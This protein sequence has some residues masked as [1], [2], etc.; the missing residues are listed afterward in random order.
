MTRDCVV[1]MQED[2]LGPDTTRFLIFPATWSAQIAAPVC[3]ELDDRMHSWDCRS[4][5]PVVLC[6][7]ALSSLPTLLLAGEGMTSCCGP[8]P[9]SQLLFLAEPKFMSLV[10]V[11]QPS[12]SSF[13][14]D[15]RYGTEAAWTGMQLPAIDI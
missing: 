4:V 5:P 8:A 13:S 6:G 7:W 11:L 12:L 14:V 3:V 9:L 15:V 10:A 1:Y 2:S